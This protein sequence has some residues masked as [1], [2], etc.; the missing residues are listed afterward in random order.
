VLTCLLQR[1]QN[2]APNWGNLRT[3]PENE[4][5]PAG[6]ELPSTLTLTPTL[7]LT[8]TLTLSLILP[9]AVAATA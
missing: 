9:T 1:S 3:P 5:R 7:T 8:L 6:S 4:Q 2:Y